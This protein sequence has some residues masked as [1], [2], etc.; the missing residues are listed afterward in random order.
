MEHFMKNGNSRRVK[1]SK[2]NWGMEQCDKN[3][4]DQAKLDKR[5]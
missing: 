2:K 3:I 5:V 1:K 4:H